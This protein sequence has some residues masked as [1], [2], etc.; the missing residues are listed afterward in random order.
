MCM[1]A[2]APGQSYSHNLSCGREEPLPGM[3]FLLP[4]QHKPKL[5]NR[6]LFTCISEVTY[7]SVSALVQNSFDQV[8]PGV[9]LTCGSSS[10]LRFSRWTSHGSDECSGRKVCIFGSWLL[11]MVTMEIGGLERERELRWASRERCSTEAPLTS[12]Q[13]QDQVSVSWTPT[14]AHHRLYIH[15]VHQAVVAE[16]KGTSPVNLLSAP[17]AAGGTDSP[18]A[19]CRWRLDQG[20]DY[21]PAAAAGPTAPPAHLHRS[22]RFTASAMPPGG[23][24]QTHL[25]WEQRRP[26]SEPT[27]VTGETWH[28]EGRTQSSLDKSWPAAGAFP[29]SGAAASAQT[30]R[31]TDQW[32]T[33]RQAK[34]GATQPTWKPLRSV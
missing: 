25:V 14:E 6:F 28:P 29:A 17:P 16:P 23:N 21:R 24:V 32:L 13:K 27:A 26:D 11:L 15:R 9:A 22:H 3:D 12:C 19:C 30:T 2:S 1:V 4:V 34:D 18:S 8:C 20:R 33:G 31:Q 7:V 10:V 5:C